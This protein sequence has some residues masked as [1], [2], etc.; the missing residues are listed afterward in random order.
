VFD[1]EGFLKVNL[2][3]QNPLWECPVCKKK[4][5]WLVKDDF[6]E[7]LLCGPIKETL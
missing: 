2:E 3:A 1:A 5:K 6:F 4:A 7:K